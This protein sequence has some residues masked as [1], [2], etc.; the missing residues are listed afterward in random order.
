[1]DAGFELLTDRLR[2][3]LYRPADAELLY[4][5]FSDPVHMQW[6]PAPYTHDRV[7]EWVEN[8]LRGSAW[9]GVW[10]AM[11]IVE[12]RSTGE[13][14]GTVGPTMPLVE[15]VL[16][17]ELGWHVRKERWGEGI[18]PEAA[19]ASRNWCWDHLEVDHLISLVRPENEPSARVAEKIGM[20][21]DRLAPYKGLMHHVYRIDRPA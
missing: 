4:P 15:N 20:R 2:L 5:P 3:R 8:Q 17:V 14:L 6:Y 7:V 19:A 16:E 9:A 10:F 21:V 13:F 1:M 12:E 18:A 11:W